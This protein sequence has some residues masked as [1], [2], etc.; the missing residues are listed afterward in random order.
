M[1]YAGVLLLH[2]WLRWAVIAAGVTASVRAVRGLT[3]RLPWL[4]GDRVAGTVFVALL[5]A[6]AVLGLLLYFV[7][8]P[9]TPKSM[10]DFRTHMAVAALRFFAVEHVF[11]MVVALASAHVGSRRTKRAGATDSAR[12]RNALVAFGVALVAVLVAIPWP[13]LPYGRPLFR[14]L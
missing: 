3:G 6:Q 11:G 4:A 12:H 9:T 8:S 13:G 7:L 5:D 14:T 10:D 2:S 1:L